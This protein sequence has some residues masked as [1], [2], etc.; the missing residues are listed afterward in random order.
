LFIVKR[1]EYLR[2]DE[3]L[4]VVVLDGL[5]QL[6]CD[7]EFLIL[8]ESQACCMSGLQLLREQILHDKHIVGL[9]SRDAAR[10]L[11]LHLKLGRT[12]IAVLRDTHVVAHL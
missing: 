3:Q 11:P 12:A 2:H 5:G 10:A 9:H 6:R 7:D 8:V 4:I 1:A